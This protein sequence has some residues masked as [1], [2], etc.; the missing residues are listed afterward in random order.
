MGTIRFRD[1]IKSAGTPEIKSLWTDPDR[2]RNFKRAA[3]EGRVLTV[4][5]EPRSKKKDFGEI[6]FRQQ[7]H[8]AYLI[9]PKKLP[10]SDSDKVVGIKYDL[11]RESEPRDVISQ[12]MLRKKASKSASKQKKEA[13]K[14]APAQ[15]IFH[16]R[17][18]QVAEVETVLAV[19]AQSK[20]EARAKAV[21]QIKSTTFDPSRANITTRALS[22]AQDLSRGGRQCRRG[23]RNY[24]PR[25]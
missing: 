9:F 7:P 12:E 5:Q 14:P 6:G 8:A 1:L 15:K 20:S 22:I 3:K 4:V 10:A 2:D 17:L 21:E 16:V 23:E 13:S 25:R 18:R 19:E 24:C 11:V